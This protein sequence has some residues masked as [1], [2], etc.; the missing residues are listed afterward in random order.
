[1]V[2]E[3]ETVASHVQCPKARFWA[4]FFFLSI[5]TIPLADEKHFSY[6]S[7]FADDQATLFFFKKTGKV[8]SKIKKIL[9][10]SCPLAL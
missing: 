3:V 1:M 4:H 5:L 8:I 10:K 9:R 7:L 6:S 2:I